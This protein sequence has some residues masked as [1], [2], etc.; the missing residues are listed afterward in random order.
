MRVGRASTLSCKALLNT[1]TGQ[2][3]PLLA[4]L[5]FG[6]LP[7]TMSLQAKQP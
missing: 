1:G 3:L 2:G 6:T 4:G 7:Q 5:C